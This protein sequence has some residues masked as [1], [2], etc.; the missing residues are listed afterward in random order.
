MNNTIII[1]MLTAFLVFSF[2]AGT[3]VAFAQDSDDFLPLDKANAVIEDDSSATSPTAVI[4]TRPFFTRNLKWGTIA[5]LASIA[6]GFCLRSKQTRG[7]RIVFLLASLVVLGFYNGACPCPILSVMQTVRLAVGKSVSWKSLVYFVGLIPVTY[8]F[9]KVWCGWVCHM[10]ALQEFIFLPS[11]FDLF[12]S[13]RAQK[14]MRLMRYILLAALIAWVAITKY[15]KWCIYDPFKTAFSLSSVTSVG[16]Y[17]LGLLLVSSLFIYRPFCKAACPIGLMLGW[18]TKIPGASVIGL[19]RKCPQ[20]M[21]C[22]K[23]CRIDAIIEDDKKYSVDNQECI[24]CG[25]CIDTCR[26]GGM[27]LFRKGS[28]HPSKFSCDDH[29]LMDDHSCISDE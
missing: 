1:K 18:V 9:G 25:E 23:S 27:R 16:W 3:G 26:L 28:A 15:P 24:A 4:Q 14:V 2:L 10:G 13:V 6:A 19:G 21:S 17:L 12:R 29:P 22:V 7:L 8:I 5:I 20:C 11:R